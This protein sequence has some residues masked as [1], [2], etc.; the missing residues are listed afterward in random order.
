MALP[1]CRSPGSPPP[2]CSLGAP[3]GAIWRLHSGVMGSSLCCS[4][5]GRKRAWTETTSKLVHVAAGSS[6][7]AR[8]CGSVCMEL[9]IVMLWSGKEHAHIPYRHQ[10]LSR[11][12]RSQHITLPEPTNMFK[13]PNA[14]CCYGTRFLVKFPGAT[15]AVSLLPVIMLPA[16]ADIC[17]TLRFDIRHVGRHGYGVCRNPQR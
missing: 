8:S 7:F 14:L 2:L 12:L 3:R 13:R 5:C 17:C 16:C 4:R 1:S 11:D 10:L 15:A 9:S 6:S